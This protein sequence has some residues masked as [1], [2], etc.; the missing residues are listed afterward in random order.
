VSLTRAQVEAVTVARC[1]QPMTLAGLDAAT[2]DGTNADLNDPIA[3]ALEYLG[4]SPADRSAVTDADLAVFDASDGAR[5]LEL[6]RI[7]TLTTCR[8]QAVALPQSQRWEDYQVD[9]GGLLVNWGRL[10]D[11]LWARY[12]DRYDRSSAPA[13][14]SLATVR[15]GFPCTAPYYPFG[16]PYGRPTC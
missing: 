6:V 8:D 7:F 5:V 1:K 15:T 2:V 9:R 10:I 4:V 3:S 11:D 14:G 16:Y 12:A 13:V